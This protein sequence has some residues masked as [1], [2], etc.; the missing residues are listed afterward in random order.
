MP[1]TLLFI[2]L[3]I[4]SFVV[5]FYLLRPT[6]TESAVQQQLQDI[7]S[8]RL[9]TSSSTILKEEGYSS[10]P[11]VPQIIRQV[12]GALGTLNLIRQSGNNWAVSTLMGGSLT[13][14]ILVSWIASLFLPSA[15][16]PVLAGVAAGS[17]P[18]IYLIVMRETRFRKC[19]QLLPEA[20]DLMARGLRAG[21]ALTAVLEMVGSE[22][23]EPI[24]TE[25]RRLSER[26]CLTLQVR[27][28]WWAQNVALRSNYQRSIH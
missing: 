18:Y 22:V 25:F 24:A 7:K 27:D 6:K 13:L 19:D 17:I 8:S 20:I 14:T 15:L 28:C 12:P 23:A 11:A 10:N 2:L 26:L 3:L 16:L 5:A 4:F 21:H 1:P 9:E